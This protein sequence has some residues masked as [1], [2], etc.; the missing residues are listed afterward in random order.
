MRG[1]TLPDVIEDLMNRLR[2]PGTTSRIAT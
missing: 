1:E 2:V